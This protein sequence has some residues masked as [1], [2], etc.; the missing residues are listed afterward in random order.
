MLVR[1][2]KVLNKFH[3]LSSGPIK[4]HFKELFKFSHQVS[5]SLEQ[6]IYKADL[7]LEDKP[8]FVAKFV[9]HFLLY[10]EIYERDPQF[11]FVFLIARLCRVER[12]MQKAMCG[13]LL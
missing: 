1:Q 2:P 12:L 11:L 8:T 3:L 10:Q 9:D 5:E 4:V 7:P 13:Y 6:N